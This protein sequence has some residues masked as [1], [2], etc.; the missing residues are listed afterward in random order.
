MG[1]AMY[2]VTNCIFR[3]PHAALE[4]SETDFAIDRRQKYLKQV[5]PRFIMVLVHSYYYIQIS[6]RNS[7]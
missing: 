3:D 1:R 6:S 2:V 7:S 4:F 5:G